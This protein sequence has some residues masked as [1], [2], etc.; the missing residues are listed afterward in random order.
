MATTCGSKCLSF[1]VMICTRPAVLA[2]IAARPLVDSSH[3]TTPRRSLWR[4]TPGSRESVSNTL[5]FTLAHHN[6]SS[7]RPLKQIRQS[8][9]IVIA[10]PHTSF[11]I[12]RARLGSFHGEYHVGRDLI[13]QISAVH[14]VACDVVLGQVRRAVSLQAGKEV[15]RE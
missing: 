1:C 2:G 13:E 4:R 15:E 6:G 7:Q 3:T 8:Q 9:I 5:P 11:N 10:E 14:P 12:R